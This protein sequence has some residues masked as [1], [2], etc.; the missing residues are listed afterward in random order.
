MSAGLF[1]F[2]LIYICIHFSHSSLT[3]GIMLRKGVTGRKNAH[4]FATWESAR[5][6]LF[7]EGS[8]CQNGWRFDSTT[9]SGGFTNN[10]ILAHGGSSAGAA[11]STWIRGSCPSG[12]SKICVECSI[13]S[14]QGILQYNIG[15]YIGYISQ[16]GRSTIVMNLPVASQNLSG[17]A[18]KQYYP[19]Y[20]FYAYNIWLEK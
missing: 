10:Y 1:F 8:G 5:Y 15:Y 7:R 4:L 13:S 18:V 17:I 19:A 6:Y 11:Q 20:G 2:I 9:V 14:G 12:Y 16:R 3:T